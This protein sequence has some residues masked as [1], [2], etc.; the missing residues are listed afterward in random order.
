[1]LKAAGHGGCDLCDCLFH[2]YL[3]TKEHV[4]STAVHPVHCLP[5]CGEG[6]STDVVILLLSL[7]L[8]AHTAEALFGTGNSC[9][10][11]QNLRFCK[12]PADLQHTHVFWS[13]RS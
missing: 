2:S 11:S 9:K 3:G 10:H 6:I 4:Y 13:Q 12:P 5:L 7:A 8:D 1:M